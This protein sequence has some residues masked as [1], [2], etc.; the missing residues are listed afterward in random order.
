[1]RYDSKHCNLSNGAFCGNR[2]SAEVIIHKILQTLCSFNPMASR[3]GVGG[4]NFHKEDSPDWGA[5][6]FSGEREAEINERSPSLDC[7]TSGF[8]HRRHRK[9]F[10]HVQKQQWFSRDIFFFL[11]GKKKNVKGMSS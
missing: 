3:S 2:S 9:K 1:M 7:E 6:G 11:G 4:G 10:C 5:E 8:E